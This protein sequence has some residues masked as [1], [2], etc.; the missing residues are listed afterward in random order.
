MMLRSIVSLLILASGAEAFTPSSFVRTNGLNTASISNTNNLSM[1]IYDWK[2]REDG[3]TRE[4]LND[5]ENTVLTLDNITSAPGS[6]KS[7]TRKGRG[8]SAGQGATCG[9]GMRGQKSRSGPNVRAG[10]E[11]GQQPLYRRLPKFVGRPT[12][13]GHTK[14][15]Y[16]IIKLDE[17]NGIA[18]GET[19]NFDSLFASKSVTKS[20]KPIHKIVVGRGEYTAKDITVQAHAF[21]AAAKAAIEA[22]GGKCQVLKRTTGA[23]IE[24]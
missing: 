19:C 12:G 11:G 1:K 10:F 15:E 2:R 24:A 17:L 13:P 8:I 20:N 23:V 5:M 14:T 16:N 18:A 3:T 21:S 6:R 4:S 9:F 22:N 7:R